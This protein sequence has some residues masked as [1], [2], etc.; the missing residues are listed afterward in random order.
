MARVAL[1]QQAAMVAIPPTAAPTIEPAATEPAPPLAASA[2]RRDAAWRNALAT[3]LDG[4][5]SPALPEQ[6]TQAIPRRHRPAA[7]AREG[8]ADNCLGGRLA[9]T[10]HGAALYIAASLQVYFTRLA[11][12]L[13]VHALRLLPQRG[14]CPV[15]GSAPVTGVVTATGR[16]P[17][18]R[19]LHC[20]L[21]AT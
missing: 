1:A 4:T 2:H 8:L 5:G 14:L 6:A 7:P 3:L 21:C 10:Q 13:P 11:S 12:T 15:C 19:Y 20:R 18:V 9:E 17:G 16:A